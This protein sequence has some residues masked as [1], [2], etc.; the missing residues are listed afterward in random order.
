MSWGVSLRPLSDFAK[1]RKAQIRKWGHQHHPDGTGGDEARFQADWDRGACQQAAENGTL[2]WQHILQ[3]EVSEAFA[4]SDLAKLREELVQ[5]GA[6]AA[7][8]IEDI[9]SRHNGFGRPL[10][11]REPGGSGLPHPAEPIR[12]EPIRDLKFVS[13]TEQIR[14]GVAY[15]QDQYGESARG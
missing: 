11:N 9:D 12:T 4:E 2:T 3:E 13:P 1:E 5:V 8:W 6:V 10:V 15:I 14:A 7:A